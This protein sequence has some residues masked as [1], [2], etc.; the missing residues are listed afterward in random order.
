MM[1]KAEKGGAE[2]DKGATDKP[3]VEANSCKVCSGRRLLGS[4]K[5]CT[6]KGDRLS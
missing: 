3:R 4:G 5:E 2:P 6:E 1:E